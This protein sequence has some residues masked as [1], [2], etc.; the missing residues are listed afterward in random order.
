MPYFLWTRDLITGNRGLDIDHRKL[1]QE[2]DA[3]LAAFEMGENSR[4]KIEK[5][6][7]LS[8]F[9][10]DHF[11]RENPVWISDSG[12]SQAY[13]DDHQRLLRDLDTL[14]FNAETGV[15]VNPAELYDF[16]RSWIRAHISSLDLK[17]FV[18]TSLV[19]EQQSRPLDLDQ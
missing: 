13:R 1:T 8:N 3:V 12:E 14:R 2:M 16:F 19:F 11:G 4:E 18:G 10:I 9:A 6:Q 5:L 17:M 7:H 15:P